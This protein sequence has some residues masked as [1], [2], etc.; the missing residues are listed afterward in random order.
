MSSCNNSNTANTQ[1]QGSTEPQLKSIFINGDSIHYIDMGKG[2]PVVFVHGALSDYRTWRN[3]IDTFAKTHRVISYSRRYAWPNQQTIIDSSKHSYASH[4][5]DL[6]ELIKAL[7][8]E[9]AHLVGHSSGAFIAMLTGMGHPELVR[10]LTL[11]EPPIVSLLPELNANRFWGPVAE[12]FINNEQEK[13]IKIFLAA[14]IDSTYF[15]RI[16]PFDREIAMA[17]PQELRAA[18]FGQDF[19]PNVTCKDLE[20]IKTPVLLLGGDK[21]FSDGSIF[22]KMEPCLSNKEKATLPTTHG[23][24][25]ENPSEFNKVVL[26]FI[27]KY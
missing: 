10:S 13:A 11:G 15:S 25:I 16:S 22:I 12:A 9:P 17:N 24:E 3:E 18:A 8:L 7:K 4:V 21:A 6:V 14:G 20:K 23:L 2:D 1:S 5:K 19:K 27:D 26:G